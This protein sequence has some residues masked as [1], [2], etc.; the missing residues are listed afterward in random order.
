MNYFEVLGLEKEPFSTSPDPEFFYLS[1][2]HE[3]ALTNSLIELQLRRGLTVILGD[4]GTGKTTLSRKF[5]QELKKRDNFYFHII[6]D[7]SFE[8]EH[9]FLDCLVRNFNCNLTK[10][11]ATTIDLK[12][13]LEAFL[14][15]KGV[16]E[17]RIVVLIIDEA[18]KLNRLSL[19]V[20]RVLLN[21]ETN[22]FK[23]LQL[24]LLGQTEFYPAIMNIPNFL[25]R[26]SFKYTLNPFGYEETKEMIG[27]RIK[28]AGY[29]GK[30]LFLDKAIRKIYQF[31]KGY[32]RQITMLCHQALKKLILDD[33]VS[34]NEEMIEEIIREERTGW[35]M[36]GSLQKKDC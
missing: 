28:Q 33:K 27:F 31:S 1:R 5:I 4:V 34:V 24:V 36:R 20:L 25:D 13:A 29:R 9:L 21:Y 22:Q 23:L 8:S 12:E 15:Q 6:F 26:V 7:P 11:E 10:E 17:N 30:Q 2:G 3:K 32:P 18:Q 19:E 35:Q 14:F 16:S